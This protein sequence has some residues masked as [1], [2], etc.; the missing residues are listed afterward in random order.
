MRITNSTLLAL[1]FA[2]NALAQRPHP[3]ER[4]APT[5]TKRQAVTSFPPASWPLKDRYVIMDNDYSNTAHIPFLIALSA[6]MTVLGLVGDTAN[7]WALQCSLHA[8]ALLEL[9]LIHISEPTR[10][11]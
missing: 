5:L 3:V 11:Y 2:P 10:P 9:S 4:D 8:L 6:N 1:A 7:S